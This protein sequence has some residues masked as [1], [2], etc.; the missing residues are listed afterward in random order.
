MQNYWVKAFT[1]SKYAILAESGEL[2][3]HHD[4]IQKRLSISYNINPTKFSEDRMK[5]GQVIMLTSSRAD[6]TGNNVTVTS[7]VTSS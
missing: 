4:V 1:S 3:R 6:F 7:L 2:W 5:N